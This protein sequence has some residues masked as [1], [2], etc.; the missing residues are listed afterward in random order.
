MNN[1]CD[2]PKEEP[3]VDGGHGTQFSL[4]ASGVSRL[5]P[6]D[7]GSEE[8]EDPK[9]PVHPADGTYALAP[10]RV[11][12]GTMPPFPFEGGAR[13]VISRGLAVEVGREIHDAASVALFPDSPTPD[14]GKG[15]P[16][17]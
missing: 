12:M 3:V 5:V 13:R 4:G 11:S 15:E 16:E 9:K 10:A 6:P 17:G 1:G 7:S 8:P 14:E 2:L